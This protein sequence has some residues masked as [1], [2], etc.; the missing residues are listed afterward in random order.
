MGATRPVLSA[1]QELKA[2]PDPAP[3]TSPSLG[4]AD[5]R[6]DA[7]IPPRPQTLCRPIPNPCA[8]PGAGAARAGAVPH[9][10]LRPT[11]F[12]QC[13]PPA[14]TCSVSPVPNP[15]ATRLQESQQ[16]HQAAT[17]ALAERD[18]TIAQLQGRMSAM[19]REY[20]QILHVSGDIFGVAP[21]GSTVPPPHRPFSH[22]ASLDLVLAKL[23]GAR[24]H[25]EEQ[26][27][28]IALQHKQRLQEFGLNP[29]E[30]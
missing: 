30:M 17:T 11:P 8:S 6:G 26:G 23:A 21:P 18:R 5:C 22:Q 1:Q 20:E 29:L 24:Q 28:A 15:A 2:K 27:T 4:G 19:E 25:W 9:C 10:P 13:Q 14:P 7:A 16:S 12:V 3:S